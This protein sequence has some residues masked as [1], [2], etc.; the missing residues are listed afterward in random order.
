M[1]VISSNPC[2]RCARLGRVVGGEDLRQTTGSPGRRRNE[3]DTGAPPLMRVQGIVVQSSVNS[4]G[5]LGQVPIEGGPR[6][7]Q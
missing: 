5:I 2:V 7:A 6:N 4:R 1:F 3:H